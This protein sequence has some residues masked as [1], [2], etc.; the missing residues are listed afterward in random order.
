MNDKLTNLI[1]S[2]PVIDYRSQKITESFWMKLDDFLALEPVPM[3][4]FTEGRANTNN[5][6]RM[7]SKL[8][9]EQVYVA[10]IELTEDSEY[11][12]T[13]YSKGYIGVVNG[14]TRAK[15]WREKLST[16]IPKDVYVSK[17]YFSSMEEVKKCYDTFDSMDATEKKHEKLYGILVRS[18]NFH[19]QSTKVLKGQILSAL[20]IANYYYDSKRFNQPS[21]KNEDLVELVIN[22]L[23]EIKTFDS[24]C[25]NEKNWDQALIAA[26]FMALKKYGNTNKR[27][28]EGLQRIDSR[29]RIM[30]SGNHYDGITHINDEWKTNSRFPAKGTGWHKA[31]GLFETVSFAL[32]WI[33]RWMEDQKLSQPGFN[34]KQTTINF[35]PKAGITVSGATSNTLSKLL[36]IDDD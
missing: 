23:D 22:F 32:Y 19:P 3:Q 31:G 24:I 12:G 1:P 29:I 18:F 14:N 30:D 28:L 11:L 33:S 9:P 10:I 25:L 15:F 34:W 27:L 13:K 5:V 8:R 2:V 35:F 6:K 26:S 4:R 21:V 16:C 20:N 17:F 7:L 36:E